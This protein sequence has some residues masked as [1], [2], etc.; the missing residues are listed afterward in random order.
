M[1]ALATRLLKAARVLTP[2]IIGSVLFMLAV[3]AS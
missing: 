3:R 2:L 1:A